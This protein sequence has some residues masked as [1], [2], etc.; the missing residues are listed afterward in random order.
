MCDMLRANETFTLSSMQSCSMLCAM[1]TTFIYAEG[2]SLVS[3]VPAT[4]KDLAIGTHY[5]LKQFYNLTQK[6]NDALKLL[7]LEI[8]HRIG[9]TSPTTWLGLCCA[10]PELGRYSRLPLVQ[11]AMKRHFDF[12]TEKIYSYSRDD[13]DTVVREEWHDQN[14]KRHR[15]DNRPAVKH[16]YLDGILRMEQW[17]QHGKLHRDGAFPAVK[18]YYEDGTLDYVTMVSE[19]H[20]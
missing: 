17:Y 7:P 16:Y 19:W 15:D 2:H 1:H 18:S 6:M 12:P 10:I 13:I 3:S 4:N 5:Y 20:A 14:G 9:E 8:W 11:A